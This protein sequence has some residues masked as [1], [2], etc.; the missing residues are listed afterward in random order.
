MKGDRMKLKQIL[1][2]V[3]KHRITPEKA[4]EMLWEEMPLYRSNGDPAYN[5]ALRDCMQVLE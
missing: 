1:E 5:Q 4:K 3:W 2:Q